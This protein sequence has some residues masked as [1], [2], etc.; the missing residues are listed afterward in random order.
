MRWIVLPLALTLASASCA[1]EPEAQQ[2]QPA[3]TLTAVAVAAYDATMFDSIAWDTEQAALDRGQ[4]VYNFSCARC[5]GVGGAGDGGF[6]RGG[7]TLRP[8]SFLR[9]DWPYTD[10]K[11]SL[12]QQVFIGTAEGMPHWGLEGLKPRDVD[13]V[14]TFVLKGL[15]KD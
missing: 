1:G 14:A 2:T 15:R 4:V 12:R 10:D 11:A 7:D 9:E 3:D 5:H 13:A 6:V 8:A